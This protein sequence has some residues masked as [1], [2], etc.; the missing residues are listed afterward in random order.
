MLPPPPPLLPPSVNPRCNCVQLLQPQLQAPA[1]YKFQHPPPASA[2]PTLTPPQHPPHPRR[3]TVCSSTVRR[4]CCDCRRALWAPSATASDRKQE[5]AHHA[6][7]STSQSQLDSIASPTTTR[8]TT[9]KSQ[10][11]DPALGSCTNL[12][13]I[14]LNLNP[15]P[16]VK[17]SPS[18]LPSH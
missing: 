11:S 13:L 9:N 5:G 16:L 2:P 3:V 1:Q 8:R 14:P 12:R 15:L 4:I 6:P 17:F 18:P 10:R 7:S